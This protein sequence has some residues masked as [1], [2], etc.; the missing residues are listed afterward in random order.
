M[1]KQNSEYTTSIDF[2]FV[3]KFLHPMLLWEL[4]DIDDDDVVKIEQMVQIGL[5]S[6]VIINEIKEESL[7]AIMKC[8]MT[9]VI[10]VEDE[11]FQQNSIE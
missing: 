10:K 2:G 5:A 11:T 8:A 3:S 7:L 6:S 1:S 9:I 4:A